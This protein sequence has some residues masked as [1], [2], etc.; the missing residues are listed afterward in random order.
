METG[1]AGRDEQRGAPLAK[2]ILTHKAQI[3]VRWEAAVRR[4]PTA[5]ELPR[6]VL[7]DSVPQLLDAIASVMSDRGFDERNVPSRIIDDH[8]FNR[9]E[10]GFDLGQVVVEYSLLREA[11]LDLWERQT[12]PSPDKAAAR[13]L[14]RAIDR[15]ISLSVD[16]FAQ[17]Q[18]RAARALDR[19]ATASLESRDLDDLLGKLLRVLIE[20]MPAVDT[21][22]IL[23]REND[24]LRVRAAVG[25]EREVELGFTLKIGEGFAGKVAAERNPV[26][27]ESAATDPLVKSPVLR[28]LGVHALYG[29]PLIEGGTVVGVA[30]IGSLTANHFSEEDRRMVGSLASRATAAIY[31]QML[32]RDAERRAAELRAVIESIPDAVYI[33]DRNG[34]T[35]ANRRGLDLLGLDPEKEGPIGHAQILKRIRARD[36]STGDEIREAEGGFARAFRG[37]TSVRELTVVRFDGQERIIRSAV[38]PIEFER[39]ID[40][41][42]SVATDIT[43]AKQYE[44]ERAELLRREH[45]ARERA[46]GAEAAARFLSEATTILASSLEYEKTLERITQLAVPQLADWCTVDL[47][48]VDGQLRTVTLAHRDPSKLEAARKLMEKYPARPD[49]PFGAPAVIRTGRAQMSAEIPDD[50]LVAISHDAEHLEILRELGLTSYIVVPIAAQDRVFGALS[51]ATGSA[52]GR[53]YGASEFATA[54]HLGRRAG[55]A[56]QNARLYRE[57]QEAARL[58][59]QVL[60]IVSHDLRNPLAAV[61]LAAD[62]VMSR[63]GQQND[64]RLN[65]QLETIRRSAARMERLIGDLLDMASIHVGKLK[66][67]R[68]A[69]PA[70]ALVDELSEAY[71]R[72]AAEAGVHFTVEH[73]V[74]GLRVECDRERILQVFSN[75]L[76]NAFKFGRRGDHITVRCRPDGNDIRFEVADTGP[77]ISPDEQKHIFEA[78][79]SAARHGKNGT[80]LGLFISRGVIEAHGR[81]IWLESE[82]GRGTTFFF[83]LPIAQAA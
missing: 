61:K 43:E 10:T 47:V 29:V 16:R 63:A 51:L 41:A 81:K 46:E 58:R 72:I 6:P 70:D 73:D 17:A 48:G 39:R 79:W 19:I 11:I 15:S 38:A 64:P 4:F 28:E 7:L 3:L 18:S 67:E 9:L 44:R 83:T 42:V 59:E 71:G 54:E 80:G 2:F 13:F 14:H 25:L 33:A 1:E 62:T 49:A 8:A 31:Q 27:L 74:A 75:L 77:G 26:F 55:L 53:R 20:T 12:F 76:G 21:A 32:R 52:P 36:A 23:L 5:R 82:P 22:A 37:E 69:H 66:I 34:I 57:A 45:D 65:R 60:A 30:H 35:T 50:L 68:R 56:I 24:L 78:Y 40:R